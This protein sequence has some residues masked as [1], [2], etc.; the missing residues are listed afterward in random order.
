MI[1]Y[2][3]GKWF[4]FH[5]LLQTTG[6][7][8]IEVM[9]RCLVSTVLVAIVHYSDMVVFPGSPYAHK[10][11]TFGLSFLVI[12]RTNL[13]YNRYWEGISQLVAMHSKWTDAALQINA[14]DRLTTGNAAT[15]GDKF[16][17]HVVH[18]MSFMSAVLVLDLQEGTLA[19]LMGQVQMFELQSGTPARPNAGLWGLRK[20]DDRAK[21]V[22]IDGV[23]PAEGRAVQEAARGGCPVHFLNQKL[24]RLVAHRQKRGGLAAPPPIVSRIFQELSNGFL[25]FQGAHKVSSVPFPFPY[26]QIVQYMQLA[27]VLSC[28][29]VVVDY[30]DTLAIQM[31]FNFLGVYTFCAL[32]AVACQLEDPFGHDVNDLPLR[33]LHHAFVMDLSAIERGKLTDKDFWCI[34]EEPDLTIPAL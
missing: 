17:N 23:G 31:F 10:C 6:G 9:P 12:M 30:V 5:K 2:D 29:V 25:A 21:L 16:R 33:Q 11:F 20:D 32:N 27:F 4:G 34:E 15:A 26:A 1:Y 19:D 24:V 28:P 14:F 7:V 3:P 22:V 13:S 18:L 8:T